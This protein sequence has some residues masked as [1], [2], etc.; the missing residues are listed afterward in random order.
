MPFSIAT[1]NTAMKP[2][3]EGTDRYCPVMNRPTMPPDDREG[4]VGDDQRGMAHRVECGVQQ[5]EDQ[6]D[7]QRHDHPQPFHR[8]LLVSKAPPHS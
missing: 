2:M 5:D 3:A 4:H 8:A 6:A 1:P 7:G